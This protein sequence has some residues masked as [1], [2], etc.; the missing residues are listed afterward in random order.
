MQ[1]SKYRLGYL[2]VRHTFVYATPD[3][4]DPD[5]SVSLSTGSQKSEELLKPFEISQSESEACKAKTNTAP[6]AFFP[7][8][9]T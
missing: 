4:E 1:E 7:S 5:L 3:P 9:F 8:P 2:P 6:A